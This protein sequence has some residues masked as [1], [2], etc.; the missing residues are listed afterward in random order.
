[1]VQFYRIMRLA[2][3]NE[4]KSEMKVK[5]KA[6]ISLTLV[7]ALAAFFIYM[8]VAGFGADGKY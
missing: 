5:T 4:R 2:Q 3:S 6:I 8:V 1:M 7:A